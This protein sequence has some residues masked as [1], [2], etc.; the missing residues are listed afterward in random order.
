MLETEQSKMKSEVT[1][2]GGGAHTWAE[3]KERG[4][5]GHFEGLVIG[6]LGGGNLEPQLPGE[7]RHCTAGNRELPADRQLA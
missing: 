2:G 1:R 3:A 6:W 4:Q 7:W 5:E